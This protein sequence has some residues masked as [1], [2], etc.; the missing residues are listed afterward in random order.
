MVGTLSF[1]RPTFCHM[2]RPPFR[3]GALSNSH[4]PT[5]ERELTADNQARLLRRVILKED[6][7]RIAALAIVT[8]AAVLAAVPARGQTYDP[9]YPVCLQTYG[10]AGGNI[11]CSYA[12]LAQCSATAS[13]RAAQCISNPF[14]AGAPMGPRRHR[15]AY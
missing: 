5:R 4:L 10:I 2:R 6:P 12:S 14:F 8:I 3:I 15:G 1:A 13:G 9:T 11:E 7:M